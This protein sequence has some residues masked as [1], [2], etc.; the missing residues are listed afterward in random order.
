MGT[1]EQNNNEGPLGAD[2][3]APTGHTNCRESSCAHRE[4]REYAWFALNKRLGRYLVVKTAKN[5]FLF[6]RVADI[7]KHGVFGVSMRYIYPGP[8]MRAAH[9]Q[10]GTTLRSSKRR[11]PWCGA[12]DD[13]PA[14]FARFS[15][16]ARNATN[17]Q[18]KGD[19]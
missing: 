7:A 17:R 2:R 1:R 8:R 6:Q 9:V 5:L 16:D 19:S 11:I 4:L 12:C 3:K 15:V 13:T 14:R 18:L 10:K